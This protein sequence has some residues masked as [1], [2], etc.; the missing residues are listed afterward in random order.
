MSFVGVVPHIFISQEYNNSEMVFDPSDP[1]IDEVHFEKKDWITS[2]FGSCIKEEFPK[3][4]PMSR[5]FGF[6]M[7]A[8]VDA[9]HAGDSMTRRSRTRFPV[10][11]NMVPIYWMSKKQTSIDTSSFGSKFIAMKQCT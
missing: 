1:V 2:E 7:R 5:G 3:N 6:V 8:F 4:M 10:Y 9:D 11:L